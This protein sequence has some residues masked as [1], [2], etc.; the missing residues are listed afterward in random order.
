MQIRKMRLSVRNLSRGRLVVELD[1]PPSLPSIQT[2]NL[3][4]CWIFLALI[5]PV[6]PGASCLRAGRRWAVGVLGR[7]QGWTDGQTDE[8]GES[9]G[10]LR[11]QVRLRARPAGRGAQPALGPAR[12]RPC[13]F[14]HRLWNSGTFRPCTG[15]WLG[16]GRTPPAV[17]CLSS[18]H[19]PVPQLH[20]SLT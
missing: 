6:P 7:G 8:L 5:S 3:R 19:L 11:A 4:T 2:F 20:S 9:E 16:H 10:E 1:T 12:G 18:Y 15:V 17:Q 13:P 14:A